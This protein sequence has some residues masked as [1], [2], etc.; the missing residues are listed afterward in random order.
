MS[1]GARSLVHADGTPAILVGD[2]AWALL[3]RATEDQVRVYAADRHAKGFNAALL[4]TVQPDMRA[5]GPRDRTQ[6]EGFDVGSGTYQV[7]TSM[8]CVDVF[9]VRESAPGHPGG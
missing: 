8:S 1:P 6:D 5:T 3:W 9:P 4:M 7:G 2:T